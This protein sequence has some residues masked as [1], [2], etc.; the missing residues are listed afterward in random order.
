MVLEL[1]TD[2]FEHSFEVEWVQVGLSVLNRKGSFVVPY[3]HFDELDNGFACLSSEL[4]VVRV[5][6]VVE[7]V[8]ST[9]VFRFF[10]YTQVLSL[11]VYRL[12]YLF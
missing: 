11:C 3:D 2:S 10:R 8:I 7:F 1:R 12:I 4:N 9:V 5:R 6:F